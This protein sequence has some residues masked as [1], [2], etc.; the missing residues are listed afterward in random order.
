MGIFYSFC[1]GDG[2]K[3]EGRTML[4]SSWIVQF[5]QQLA[6]PLLRQV[7]GS[8]L[9]GIS[10]S[11]HHEYNSSH[12]KSLPMCPWTVETYR[13][14]PDEYAHSPHQSYAQFDTAKS[15]CRLLT[16]YSEQPA[17][18]QATYSHSFLSYYFFASNRHML[19]KHMCI[20]YNLDICLVCIHDTHHNICLSSTSTSAG[21]KN[22]A[23]I[24]QRNIFCVV[25]LLSPVAK[26]V[27]ST[28]VQL[29]LKLFYTIILAKVK[30]A[31]RLCGMQWV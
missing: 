15:F 16:L 17:T 29:R 22:R 1:P 13:S 2:R 7:K 21:K 19:D 31:A 30:K 20:A 23:G 28:L 9:H 11:S 12:H 4:P 8:L 18:A 10:R 3:K 27:D 14:K 26:L 5:T 6:P 24:C 25:R